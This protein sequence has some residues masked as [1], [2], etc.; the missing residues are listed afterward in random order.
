[1]DQLSSSDWV[2]ACSPEL[3]A[4]ELYFYSAPKSSS[5]A[6]P[7]A[8]TVEFSDSGSG[9]GSMLPAGGGGGPQYE[10]LLVDSKPNLDFTTSSASYSSSCPAQPIAYAVGGGGL[11]SAGASAPMPHQLAFSLQQPI[12]TSERITFMSSSP[13]TFTDGGATTLVTQQEAAIRALAASQEVLFTST[14]LSSSGT[15]GSVNGLEASGAVFSNG[16]LTAV[17]PA[18][19]SLSAP[20]T[21]ARVHSLMW[22]SP[23]T[24]TSAVAASDS[25]STSC[26]LF[27]TRA[28]EDRSAVPE[29]VAAGQ[30]PSTRVANLSC[31]VEPFEPVSSLPNEFPAAPVSVTGVLNCAKLSTQQHHNLS[32][33]MPMTSYSSPAST[34]E[35]LTYAYSPSFAVQ[36]PHFATATLH[37]SLPSLEP[38]PLPSLQLLPPP[39]PFPPPRFPQQSVP[40]ETS[41]PLVQHQ[42][43]YFNESIYEYRTSSSSTPQFLRQDLVGHQPEFNS[44]ISAQQFEPFNCRPQQPH[45]FEMAH[46]QLESPQRNASASSTHPFWPPL[47]ADGAAAPSFWPAVGLVGSGVDVDFGA[48]VGR[49]RSMA[50]CAAPALCLS[51]A[52]LDLN[53]VSGGVCDGGDVGRAGAG[54]CAGDAGAFPVALAAAHYE[55]LTPEQRLLVHKL[56]PERILCQVCGDVSAGYHCGGTSTACPRNCT[57]L[58]SHRPF[59]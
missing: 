50:S 4:S 34:Q 14:G 52:E 13:F 54:A 53:C 41:G 23:P 8:A 9:S 42:E 26:Q 49:G 27:S 6:A 45:V 48:G 37:T 24:S 35:A 15:S 11:T 46:T 38:L 43:K 10:A 36:A 16:S 56:A 21:F 47:G 29:V 40:L 32:F 28:V 7:T 55:L 59:Q 22:T 33:L 18:S 19:A 25:C 2:Y 57:Y 58:N 31:G 3:S 12:A 44:H 17:C 5:L 39:P 1:M 30:G 20:I 51:G